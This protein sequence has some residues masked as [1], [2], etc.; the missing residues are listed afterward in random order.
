[1]MS[2]KED[3]QKSMAFPVAYWKEQAKAIDWFKF[4]ENIL[5]KDEEELYRWYEP[6]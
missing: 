6:H 1:M 4:P 2:Y 5:S 3:Y